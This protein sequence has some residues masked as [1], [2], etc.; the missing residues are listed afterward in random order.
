[1]PHTDP[2][3]LASPSPRHVSLLTG[4]L[5]LDDLVLF[6]GISGFTSDLIS[7]RFLNIQPL[8]SVYSQ[9]KAGVK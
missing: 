1:M 3:S 7:G 2:G 9:G 4:V 6:L 5:L 8:G